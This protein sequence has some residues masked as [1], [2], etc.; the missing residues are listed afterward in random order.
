VRQIF[1]HQL[2]AR[3]RGGIKPLSRA[4]G[5]QGLIICLFRCLLFAC[6]SR[7]IRNAIASETG[8]RSIGIVLPSHLFIR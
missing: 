1:F 7:V 3:K 6:S 5:G 4:T 8:F 2:A